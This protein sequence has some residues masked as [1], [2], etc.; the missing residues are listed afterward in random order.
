WQWFGKGPKHDPDEI[1]E[2]GRRD[3]AA[4]HYP[5]IGPYDGRDPAVLEYHML[6]AK[7]AGIQGFFADWYGPGTYSDRVFAEMVKAA[8]RY[9][10]KVAICLEEKAFFPPYSKAQTRADLKDEMERHIRHVLETHAPSPA[11]LRIHG[12][13]AFFVFNGYGE[14]PLGPNNLSPEEL[15]DVLG[16]FDEGLFYF[17]HDID[18]AYSPVVQGSYAWIANDPAGGERY[19]QAAQAAR[20]K[21]EIAYWIGVANPGFDDSGVH[22]W[23]N[24]PRIVDRRGTR[25]YEETWAEVLKYRPDG[26]QVATWND[27][28]E[29]TTIEPAAEYGFT[30]VNLTEEYVARFT[31]RPADTSDNKW[32]FRLHKLRRAVASL[33]DQAAR[34]KASAR[35][36]AYAADFS[37]GKRFLMGLRLWW[38]EFRVGGGT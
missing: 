35:L 17:R 29:G 10:M 5:L 22:G 27:F 28:Q 4:V 6:T 18:P 23:G 7:A 20:E 21:G 14:G 33:A 34:D 24:G 31:G 8:E 38:L 36:D 9:G 19:N 26:V 15:A 30:F 3:I 25:T 1:L 2:N 12:R 32:P 11:Y 16:R 37:A 13:P